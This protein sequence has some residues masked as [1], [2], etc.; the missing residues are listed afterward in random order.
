MKVELLVVENCAHAESAAA[1]L[2][3]CLDEVGLGS[4]SFQ[5]RV[6]ADLEDAERSRFVGS[7]A[8]LL[9][10]VDHFAEPGVPPGVSCRVYRS[11]FG[12]AG[13]PEPT[14]LRK[15]LEQVAAQDNF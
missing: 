7:P 11:S 12:V 1:L 10:G 14:D 15:V 9:N 2:R 5:T 6:I 3:Q 13:L 8:F 4:T